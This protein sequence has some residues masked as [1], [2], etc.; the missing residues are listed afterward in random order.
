MTGENSL[1]TTREAALTSL[2]TKRSEALA[3]IRKYNTL[4]ENM[5][6]QIDGANDLLERINEAD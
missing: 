5:Q 4:K 6:D 1:S 3:A 2:R